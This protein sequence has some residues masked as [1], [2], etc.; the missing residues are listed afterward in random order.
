ML[1][2]MPSFIN[3]LIRPLSNGI[4]RWAERNLNL[5][6]CRRQTEKDT[7]GLTSRILV[8]WTDCIS[9]TMRTLWTQLLTVSLANLNWLLPPFLHSIW[10]CD[11]DDRNDSR[12][13]FSFFS[14]ASAHFS[15]LCEV[16][17]ESFEWS[18]TMASFFAFFPYPF[19]F[20]LYKEN[21][22]NQCDIE[23]KA[24]SQGARPGGPPATCKQEVSL[25][26]FLI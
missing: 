25:I 21:E 22:I 6:A 12:F 1:L 7:K 2:M 14:F 20:K 11:I 23:W 18:R 10:T 8:F 24:G 3:S 9:N 17:D 19:S 13:A 26:S 4:P 16:V 15:S 5:V